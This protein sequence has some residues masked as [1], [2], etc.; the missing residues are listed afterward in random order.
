MKIRITGKGLSIFTII[1]AFIV[2]IT[3]VITFYK[4]I[5]SRHQN[6]E[7]SQIVSDNE[8]IDGITYV[9]MSDIAYENGYLKEYV[10]EIKDETVPIPYGYSYVSG[11]KDSGLIIQD[12]ETKQT[13][14]WIPYNE[15]A[16]VENIDEYYPNI[17]GSEIDYDSYLSMQKHKGFFISIENI[18]Q[19]DQLKSISQSDFNNAKQQIE[20]M[21]D[22]E[23]TDIHLISKNE[24]KQILYFQKN[25]GINTIQL[26]NNEKATSI[27]TLV[28]LS[29]NKQTA[30]K[31]I[32]EINTEEY[33]IMAL[34]QKVWKKS[35]NSSGAITFYVDGQGRK[36][37]VPVG[38]TADWQEVAG[39]YKFIMKYNANENL[40]FV[41]FW[42]YG[43]EKKEQILNQYLE[44]TATI[45]NSNNKDNELIKASL[46]TY[47][48]Y[49]IAQSEL[50]KIEGEYSTK[51][52][53][54]TD[55]K[56]TSTNG[57]PTG[58]G[59][60]TDY[61]RLDGNINEQQAAEIL[62]EKDININLGNLGIAEKVYAQGIKISEEVIP[63][64]GTMKTMMLNTD[65]NEQ[66][67]AATI[68]TKGEDWVNKDSGGK[69]TKTIENGPNQ[70]IE[71]TTDE[72]LMVR[73]S[74]K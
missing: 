13:Y 2:A 12:D 48:G 52:V 72:N 45:D 17:S 22:K 54:T 58:V 32:E 35:N 7:I 73:S 68:E 69:G 55:N 15:E 39:Q 43:D 74:R 49:W 16:E 67:T 19:Y 38:F 37:P 14:M 1:L 61:V 21:D 29:I 5:S 11:Q 6:Q 36:V 46:D 34:S 33:G 27:D 18:N 53:S 42:T 62:T 26:K 24:L 60:D 50:A 59:T 56:M 23:S 71:D 44:Y 66:L 8:V 40:V 70:S 10:K 63:S 9:N 30:V 64:N 20:D 51:A 28:N 47:G 57:G 4:V 31:Q 65:V 25:T 41:W 3:S